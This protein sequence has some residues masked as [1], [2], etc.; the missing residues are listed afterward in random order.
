MLFEL[1]RPD[2]ALENETVASPANWR[3]VTARITGATTP[4]RQGERV[5]VACESLL[6]VSENI[7]RLERG[8]R[9]RRDLAA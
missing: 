3:Q 6:W 1:L 4:Q 7:D 9:E 2:A 5:C 8:R